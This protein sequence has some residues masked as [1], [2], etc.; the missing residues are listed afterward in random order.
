MSP[1]T[2]RFSNLNRNRVTPTS[3]SQ[4]GAPLVAPHISYIGSVVPLSLCLFE[5]STCSHRLWGLPSSSGSPSLLHLKALAPQRPV[6][7][8]WQGTVEPQPPPH[9]R[10]VV[11]WPVA[12]Q[13]F[14][15]GQPTRYPGSRLS[16]G[17]SHSPHPSMTGSF[18][19]DRLLHAV[20]QSLNI[21]VREDRSYRQTTTEELTVLVH[22]YPHDLCIEYVCQN[23]PRNSLQSQLVVETRVRA[24][25]RVDQLCVAAVCAVLLAA[26]LSNRLG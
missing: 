23:Y 9:A 6:V 12:R 8:S 22:L 7:S 3:A 13:G 15:S 19:D 14:Y 4:I 26:N 17:R 2:A 10:S 18:C 20:T 24:L 25:G 1:L 11:A 21:T 5:D 16:R